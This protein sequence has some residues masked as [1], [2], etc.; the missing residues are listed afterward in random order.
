LSNFSH[1]W[2]AWNYVDGNIEWWAY[3]IYRKTAYTV[4]PPNWSGSC[5]LG[6]IIHPSSCSHL[7]EGHLLGSPQKTACLIDDIRH[8]R[9]GHR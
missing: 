8:V 3:W 2:Q 4:L 7:P 9:D 6:S 5:V 1:L